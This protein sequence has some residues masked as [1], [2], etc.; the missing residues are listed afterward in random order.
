MNVRLWSESMKGHLFVKM[1]KSG[2]PLECVV[3]EASE[4]PAV[5]PGIG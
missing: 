2:F 4:L 5:D 3:R 1:G